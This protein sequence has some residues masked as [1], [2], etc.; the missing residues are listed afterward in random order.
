MKLRG[1]LKPDAL[2]IN[3]AELPLPQ[4]QTSLNLAANY[5]LTE[6]LQN[7]QVL[8]LVK[9]FINFSGSSNVGGCLNKRYFHIQI[10]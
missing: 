8:T 9:P 5:T 2:P 6:Y 1:S 4:W 10:H 3:S 7:S